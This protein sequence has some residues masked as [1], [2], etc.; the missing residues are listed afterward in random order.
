M[1]NPKN[2]R[3]VSFLVDLSFEYAGTESRTS[4]NQFFQEC[5]NDPL[6]YERMQE[7]PEYPKAIKILT[8]WIPGEN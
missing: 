6:I 2:K 5:V 1:P 8:T 4:I 3:T 7:L